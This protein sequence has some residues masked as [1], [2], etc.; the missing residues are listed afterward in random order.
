MKYTIEDDVVDSTG[1]VIAKMATV[2]TGDG[3][4]PVV[5]TMGTDEPIGFK[6]TGEPI[7]PEIDEELLSERQREFR[8][9]AIRQQ[10]ELTEK[11]GGD[12]DMVNI[13]GVTEK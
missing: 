12:P 3:S 2:I 6:D 4:T 7:F 9:L 5:M 1:K 11:N 13:I 8:A 10:K